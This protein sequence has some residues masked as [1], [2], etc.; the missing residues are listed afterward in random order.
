MRGR[1][2]MTVLVVGGA[3]Y[4]GS[5]MVRVLRERGI[6]VEVLDNLCTGHRTALEGVRLHEVDLLDSEGT[7]AAVRA[8]KPDCVMH[9]AAKALVAESV[10]DPGL[11]YRNN[12]TGTLNLLDAM[13]HA[14]VRDLIFSSTCAVYGIPQTAVID[15]NHPTNPI[16]PYGNSKRCAELAI[17]DYCRSYGLLAIS[18]RY[19]NAAG[20][21]PSGDLG[22]DHDPETHL[23]P[24]VLRY[25]AGLADSLTVFGNDHPTLDGYCVRDYVHVM[26]LCDA[27]AL[28][29]QRL[30]AAPPGTFEVFNLG[31]G[32]GFSVK[33]VIETAERVVGHRIEYAPAERRAGDPPTLVASAGR[34]HSELGWRPQYADLETI[35]RTANAWHRGSGR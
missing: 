19:F 27:H 10:T 22:E 7:R 33:E 35:I 23:I 8:C 9:F 24:N 13:R 6:G 25:A 14:G 2:N 17:E 3:G 16:N 1:R 31:N 4:I 15:E 29:M 21:H 32:R 30:A 18:L 26:D 20:A 5:H 34:A 12:V 11:Y 28:A